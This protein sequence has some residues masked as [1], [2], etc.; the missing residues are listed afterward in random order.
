LLAL[1]YGYTCH[2]NPP[3]SVETATLP[4]LLLAVI[5]K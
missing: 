4:F 5:V 1:D 3:S 2:N